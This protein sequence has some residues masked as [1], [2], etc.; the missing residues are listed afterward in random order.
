MIPVAILCGGKGTRLKPL[1]AK[2]PKCLVDVNGR[3]FLVHQLE[4]L[5]R[6]GYTDVLLLSGY[7]WQMIRGVVGDGTRYG[8]TIRHCPD[9]EPAFGT[10]NA[11]LAAR[12]H[13]GPEFFV[14]YGDSYLDCDYQAVEA[15][16]MQSPQLDAVLTTY[17]G[18]DY[19]LRAFRQFPPQTWMEYPMARRWQEIGSHEGLERV[20]ALTR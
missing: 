14:L 6:N 3:P 16:L 7:L 11:I 20:R 10:D 1:T 13:L 8:M 2:L 5:K 15:A 4:L 17:E 9:P 18:V 12:P 19:G